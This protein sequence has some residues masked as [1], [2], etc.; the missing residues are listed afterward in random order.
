MNI[1]T[2]TER[3]TIIYNPDGSLKGSEACIHTGYIEERKV[4]DAPDGKM[5]SFVV[6]NQDV[7]PVIAADFAPILDEGTELVADLA[8]KANAL[9][10]AQ[11]FIDTI[12]AERDSLASRLSEAEQTIAGQSA[13]LE[14]E[15]ATA[16]SFKTTAEQR[17]IDQQHQIAALTEKL[18]GR[19]IVFDIAA[20]LYAEKT[21]DDLLTDVQAVIAKH[22]ATDQSM[23]TPEI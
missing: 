6:V 4:A 20:K 7:R 3:A 9:A 11:A 13:S 15:R 12:A 16:M 2:Y 1:I 14:S 8:A 5:K 21:S 18:A 17:M 19:D 10:L 23:N 22:R